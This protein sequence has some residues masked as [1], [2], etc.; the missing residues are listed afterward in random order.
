MKEKSITSFDWMSDE[1]KLEAAKM[2]EDTI[3][4]DCNLQKA[5]IHGV[6]WAVKAM[7]DANLLEKKIIK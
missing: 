5:F 1:K 7:A 3:D 2:Y 4:T 6:K